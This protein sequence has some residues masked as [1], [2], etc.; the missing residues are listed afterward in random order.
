[1]FSETNFYK[2]ILFMDSNDHISNKLVNQLH[3]R[4]GAKFGIQLESKNV[5]VDS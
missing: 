1:M 4:I 3:T 5:D 2:W